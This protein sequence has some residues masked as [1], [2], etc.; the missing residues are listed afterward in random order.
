MSSIS[1]RLGDFVARLAAEGED[2]RAALEDK[3]PAE[4]SDFYNVV[5]AILQAQHEVLDARETPFRYEE[6]WPE[7]D[8]NLSSPVITY[9]L[10]S[11]KPA[12]TNNS[13]HGNP[14]SAGATRK[15]NRILFNETAFESEPGLVISHY[16]KL[17]DNVVEFEV[18][19]QTNKVATR[20]ALWIESTIG[21]FEDVLRQ[22]GFLVTFLE[23]KADE[24][25][26]VGNRKHASRKVLFYVRT[27]VATADIGTV[28]RYINLNWSLS[29]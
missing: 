24:A 26:T 16:A 23:Q 29:D 10:K 17:Y 15:Y 3:A 21:R 7:E 6:T 25:G 5:G 19:A 11:R 4:L 13:R 28:L 22:A 8:D 2:L 12:A 14:M 18:T 27:Q 20:V 9:T 1:T